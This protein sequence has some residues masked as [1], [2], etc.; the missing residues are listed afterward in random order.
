[1]IA[2]YAHLGLGLLS[3]RARSW[4][5]AQGHFCRTLQFDQQIQAIGKPTSTSR[6]FMRKRE[7]GVL[8]WRGT[9]WALRPERMELESAFVSRIS[10]SAGA[11][12]LGAWWNWAVPWGEYLAIRRLHRK[13]VYRLRRL[14]ADRPWLHR[15]RLKPRE[16]TPIW[17]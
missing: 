14:F 16:E 11:T 4:R 9:G 12:S 2:A 15:L 10:F 1:M 13:F 5:Q 6:N 8:P 3:L 17:I 7:T